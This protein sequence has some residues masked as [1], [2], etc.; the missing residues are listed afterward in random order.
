MEKKTTLDSSCV[1]KRFPLTT[2]R[3]TTTTCAE[4]VLTRTPGNASHDILTLTPGHTE[5]DVLPLTPTPEFPPQPHSSRNQPEPTEPPH[6][7][8]STR[9]PPRIPRARLPE[10]E[11]LRIFV[12]CQRQAPETGRLKQAPETLTL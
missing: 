8:L 6:P 1:L 10:P 4:N 3:K 5:H 11:I 9:P 2:S 12:C 7:P